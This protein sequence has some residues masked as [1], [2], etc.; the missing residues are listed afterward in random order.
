M[1]IKNPV[2]REPTPEERKKNFEES[3][4]Y[5]ALKTVEKTEPRL[6][7]DPLKKIQPGELGFSEVI[8]DLSYDPPRV[9]EIFTSK[10]D[11]GVLL[12]K[13]GNQDSMFVVVDNKTF[14]EKFRVQRDL[15]SDLKMF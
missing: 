9:V 5:L 7:E 4:R 11:P 10:E 15:M 14:N 6:C 3:Q 12:G 13:M 2:F 1:V 8:L